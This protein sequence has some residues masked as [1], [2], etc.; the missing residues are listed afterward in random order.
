MLIGSTQKFRDGTTIIMDSKEQIKIGTGL[1]IVREGKMLITKRK[2][3][4]GAGSFGTL[5]G[6]VEFGEHPSDALR[7]EAKE[8]LDIEIGNLEFISCSSV[9]KYGKQ[10]IDVSFTADIISGEPKI[11][12][13]D[14]IESADWYPVDSLPEPLF[15]Y[16]KPVLEAWKTKQAYREIND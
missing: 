9:M 11:M 16:F 4:M 8:E 12:E 13:P 2:G 15:E 1:I 3:N 5:G 7:R 10:Y 14:K 6:H